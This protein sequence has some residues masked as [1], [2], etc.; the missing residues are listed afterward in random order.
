MTDKTDNIYQKAFDKVSD[1][2]FDSGVVEVFEDMI[3]R[4]VPGYAAILGMTGELATQFAQ[5]HTAIYDLGCSLGGSSIS[6]AQRTLP[7]GVRI[8]ALDNSIAMVEGLNNKLATDAFKQMPIDLSCEDI[9]ATSFKPSSF[10]VMNFTLQFIQPDL[11]DQLINKIYDSLVPGGAL[12]LSEKIKFEDP[13][14]DRLI[15]DLHHKF[16][17]SMGYSDLEIAQKRSAIENILLP[18][19][20][21]THFERMN[22]AGF[23]QVTTWF[24]CF[25]FCSFLAVKGDN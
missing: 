17:K 4:S 23:K 22:K 14:V 2:R 3:E 24:Q 8:Q 12:L 10:V 19:T 15:V 6:M 18:E 20:S 1:F 7:Q 11:R 21:Q 5:P 13:E 16:K 9:C 25:N